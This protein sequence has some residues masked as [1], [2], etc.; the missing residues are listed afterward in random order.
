MPDAY[1]VD[2][3]EKA[4]CERYVMYCIEN[5]CFTN[6]II[7]NNTINFWRK[8]KVSL[9]VVFKIGQGDFLKVHGDSGFRVQRAGCRMPDAGCRMPVAG[10]R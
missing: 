9:F 4:F 7:A 10:S 6:T 5:I 3:V 8:L 1:A 2:I